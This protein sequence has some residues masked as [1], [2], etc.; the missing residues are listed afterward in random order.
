MIEDVTVSLYK[1]QLLIVAHAYFKHEGKEILEIYMLC[2]NS[3]L[4]K[5][6]MMSGL[7]HANSI[8]C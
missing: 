8:F 3:R 4:A 5:I 7:C 2:R 1:S 6:R